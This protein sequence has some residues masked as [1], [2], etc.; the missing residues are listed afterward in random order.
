MHSIV[1]GLNDVEVL[2]LL[3]VATKCKCNNAYIE[4]NFLTGNLLLS[5]AGQGKFEGVKREGGLEVTPLQK[6]Q[7]VLLWF[8]ATIPAPYEPPGSGL[9]E[10]IKI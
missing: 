6:V 8:P 4:Q 5:Q 1:S 7:Q 2:L 9:S 10:N 3:L